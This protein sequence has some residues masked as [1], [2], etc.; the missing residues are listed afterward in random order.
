MMVGSTVY[1]S[2]AGQTVSVTREP[3]WCACHRACCARSG[4]RRDG[5]RHG[6]RVTASSQSVRQPEIDRDEYVFGGRDG[7][8]SLFSL[9]SVHS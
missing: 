2:A 1:C 8:F 6:A 3:L 5:A 4:R 9:R 7:L